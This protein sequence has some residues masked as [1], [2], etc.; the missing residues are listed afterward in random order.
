MRLPLAAQFRYRRGMCEKPRNRRDLGEDLS[1]SDY[2]NALGHFATG[3]TVVTAPTADG[4]VGITANS[5]ASVSLTP[6]LVSWCPARASARCEAFCNADHFAIH[7]LAS[8]QLE[9]ARHFARDAWDFATVQSTKG[10]HGLTIL[11]DCAAVLIC[12]RHAVH[13]AGDHM[14]V[15]GEVADFAYADHPPLLFHLGQFSGFDW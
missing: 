6:R 5:F 15:L 9:L 4:P 12:R 1:D 14:I 13:E 2:R 3:V 8:G 11:K 10:P 7:I